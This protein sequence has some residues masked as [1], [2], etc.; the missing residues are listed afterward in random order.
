MILTQQ[1]AYLVLNRISGL[2]GA[3]LQR[4]MEIFTPLESLFDASAAT[5]RKAGLSDEWIRQVVSPDLE[6]LE[7]DQVWLSQSGCSLLTFSDSDYPDNLRQISSPPLVLFCRGARALLNVPHLAM[8][9]SRSPTAGGEETAREFA[10]AL[11]EAGIAIVSGLAHGIDRAAHIGALGASGSTIAVMA[12]GPDR[13]YPAKNRELACEIAQKGLLLTE[14]PVGVK[15]L[16]ENF[17]RRNRIISGLA[18]GTLVVEAAV[19][20]GTLVTARY[21]YDQGREVFAIPGSIHNPLSKGCHQ[22]IKQGAKLVES[23]E[24]IL[25]ELAPQLHNWLNTNSGN[26]SNLSRVSASPIKSVP[27]HPHEAPSIAPEHRQVWEALGHDPVTVDH[28]IQ[29]TGLTA[30]AICSMLVMMEIEGKVLSG[31]GGRWYRTV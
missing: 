28:L 1:D 10:Y 17:P 27:S 16:K 6:A 21:A 13:V 18:L 8:V 19:K 4:L 26:L 7:E 15:P 23:V 3:A 24:D 14:F 22:L 11:S 5:L 12:T 2:G 20:S 25:S 30:E 31:T 9:G 29:R